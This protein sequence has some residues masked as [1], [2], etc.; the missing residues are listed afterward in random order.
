MKLI[1]EDTIRKILKA[2][3]AVTDGKLT[4]PADS[5]ITMA[6]M[7]V[8]TNA[9]LKLELTERPPSLSHNQSG[10]SS[11]KVEGK[12]EGS[13]K[14]PM[15]KHRY[16]IVGGGYLDEKPEHLTQLHRNLLVPKD[17]LRIRLRGE[18]DLLLAEVLKVQ[19]RIAVLDIP[20]LLEDLEDICGYIRDLS[21]A[22]IMDEPFSD[23]VV[24]GM[25]LA[26]VHEMSHHPKQYFGRGHLF[27]ISYKDGE[28]T[29][30]LNGLRAM[31]RQCELDFY[32]AF[33]DKDGLVSRPDL[34]EGYNRLSSAIYL[35]CLRAAT[36][37]YGD[38]R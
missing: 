15:D 14:V 16:E 21:R 26:E 37:Q 13:D 38:A 4:L 8:I 9:K 19:V 3:K 28:I 27:N 12:R 1:T 18:I 24:L 5:M 29:V 34:M 2:G 11:L 7:D 31:S 10:P 33:K 23:T 20:R 32:E 30:L 36:G 25:P 35:L 22:E 17:D 6:A